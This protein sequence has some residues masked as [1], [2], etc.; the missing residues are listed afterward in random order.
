M[1]WRAM[2]GSSAS[3]SPMAPIIPPLRSADGRGQPGIGSKRA[4]PPGLGQE[5]V[6]G[7]T[8]SVEHGLVAAGEHA[9]AEPAVSEVEPDALDGIE[10]GTIGRQVSQGQVRR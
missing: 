10:L 5:G 9:V 8:G 4:E 3:T 7:A 1:V 2:A 6:P